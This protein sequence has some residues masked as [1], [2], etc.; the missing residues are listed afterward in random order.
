MLVLP[1]VSPRRSGLGPGEAAGDQ[2]LLE[3]RAGVCRVVEP[4]KGKN[5][6]LP[7][8]AEWEYAA[9]AGT[10]TEYALP[11][12]NGSDNIKNK[13][14]PTART[15]VVNGTSSKRHRS[16]NFQPM[17]GDCTTCTATSL[18]GWRIVRTRTTRMRR[19]TARHWLAPR[20]PYV[21][22][23]EKNSGHCSFRGLRGGSGLDDQVD[24][25]SAGR[26]GFNPFY[27]SAA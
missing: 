13:G 25:R 18:S 27:G 16:G 9:R 19:K 5:C 11:S 7:S 4:E 15:A 10:T 17:P 1:T 14:W 20:N 22:A 24:A 6:R 21:D 8:E 12:P 23:R 26:D 2:R 3:G